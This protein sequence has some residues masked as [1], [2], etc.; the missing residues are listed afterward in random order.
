MEG[1]GSTK[2]K[3]SKLH[4]SE[5]KKVPDAEVKIPADMRDSGE[6]RWKSPIRELAEWR[7]SAVILEKNCLR[8]GFSV[9]LAHACWRGEG[10]RWRRTVGQV[11]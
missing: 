1:T 10:W 7:A 4:A 6:V 11:H 8:W 2:V 3:S 9:L 5:I